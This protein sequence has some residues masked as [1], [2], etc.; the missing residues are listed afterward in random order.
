MLHSLIIGLLSSVP[1]DICRILY[2]IDQHDALIVNSILHRADTH[3]TIN[4]LSIGGLDLDGSVVN[5]I[6]HLFMPIKQRQFPIIA[7]QNDLQSLVIIEYS[8]N[9]N[10]LEVKG[11][12]I[13]T[14]F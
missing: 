1:V 10:D 12:D 5:S 14:H 13:L 6:D 3:N 7:G 4:P 8:V 9:R 2:G 11:L